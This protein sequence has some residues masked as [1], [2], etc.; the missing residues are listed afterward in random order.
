MLEI[1][2]LK[3]EIIDKTIIDGLNLTINDGEIHYLMGPNGVG[4]ST[5]A[6]VLMHQDDY[7]VSNGTIKYN[8]TD[9]NSLT[10][11][12]IARLG[13]SMVSQAP[14]EVEGVTNAEMLRMALSSRT[15][16]QVNIFK[17]NKELE[18]VC[19]K[20]GVP[21]SF[22]HRNINE[23]MSG[24]ERKKGELVHIW[25]LKPNF[26]ILDEIDSGLDIDSLKIVANSLK[27]Y[28]ETYN[29]S[30]LIITHNSKM[31]EILKPDYIHILDNKKI[32]KTGNI[33]LLNLL[34]KSGFEAFKV[35]E[36]KNHE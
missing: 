1:K 32:V 7:K 2:N 21:K 5:I 31:L 8:G 4:K 35:S 26:L 17:F 12:E 27:E 10:T 13:I 29:A 16:E 23:G 33:E 14:I 6:K 25:M 9:L 24:G 19:E 34:E 30:M 36:I 15:D 22:I 18:Q 28:K 3:V 11:D 20:L